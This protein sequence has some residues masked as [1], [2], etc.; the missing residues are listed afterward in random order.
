M[1]GKGSQGLFITTSRFTRDAEIEASR[2]GVE[3]IDLI[4]GN[5]L[6][7]LMRDHGLGTE[8]ELVEQVSVND[9]FFEAFAQKLNFS[10]R[11]ATHPDK[12]GW[13]WCIGGVAVGRPLDLS[14]HAYTYKMPFGLGQTLGQTKKA[15]VITEAF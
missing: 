3:P 13:Y 7:E 1:A 12:C 9:E 2:D 15:P 10:V 5:E 4:D 6:C 8:V 14:G 11:R